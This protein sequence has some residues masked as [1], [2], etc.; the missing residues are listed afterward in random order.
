[1]SA[2]F[3]WSLQRSPD[4]P[5]QYS[6]FHLEL[7]SRVSLITENSSQCYVSVTKV[8]L[9]TFICVWKDFVCLCVWVYMC[10]RA[11]GL[12]VCLQPDANELP[13]FLRKQNKSYLFVWK[14]YTI[15][16]GHNM[17]VFHFLGIIPLSLS[18]PLTQLQRTMLTRKLVR[19]KR[20]PP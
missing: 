14:Q 18:E 1:M 15:S 2:N 6:V 9:E 12:C 20:C 19:E 8:L 10:M 5:L 13:H 4:L 11:C 16:N 17:Q 3:F 7:T